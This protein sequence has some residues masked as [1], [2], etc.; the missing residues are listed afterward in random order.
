MDCSVLEEVLSGLVRFGVYF[1]LVC[2]CF[3]GCLGDSVVV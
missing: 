2:V 1:E 3:R